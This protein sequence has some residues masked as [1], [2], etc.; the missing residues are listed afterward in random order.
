MKAL[1]W[2][3]L[4]FLLGQMGWDLI[5]K[6]PDARI[7]ELG[8]QKLSLLRFPKNKWKVEV[9]VRNH[10]VDTGGFT[11]EEFAKILAFELGLSRA[12]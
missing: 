11:D 12:L 2:T 10:I 7:F 9:L 5:R 6:T 4:E 3:R 8:H 1:T